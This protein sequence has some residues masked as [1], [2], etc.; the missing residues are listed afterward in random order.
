MGYFAEDKASGIKFCKGVH[1][2]PRQ[3]ITNFGE[4]CSPDMHNRTNRPAR[5]H[6][7]NV[8]ND[9]PSAPKHAIA[10]RVDIGSA[11]MDIS[12]SPQTDVLVCNCFKVIFQ[13]SKGSSW[14]FFVCCFQ[15]CTTSCRSTMTSGEEASRPQHSATCSEVAP[16]RR[17]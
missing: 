16:N 17:C 5:H 15:S 7:H 13:K 6:L 4:L 11:C 8:D 2:R 9:Y 3:G 10:Q 12:P 1:W 14:L